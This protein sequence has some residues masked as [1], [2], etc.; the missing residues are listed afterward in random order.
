MV[1][2]NPRRPCCGRSCVSDDALHP[3]YRRNMQSTAQKASA[4]DLGR[5][6][7]R[8]VTRFPRH[9]TSEEFTSNPR[10]VGQYIGL[11]SRIKSLFPRGGNSPAPVG[12][13]KFLINID[14]CCTHP[15]CTS[16][17][18]F[19]P[20]VLGLSPMSVMYSSC[21]GGCGGRE[22]GLAYGAGGGRCISLPA[23]RVASTTQ[24]THCMH[25]AK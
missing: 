2:K 1:D 15:S 10:F 5:A 14:F 13:S 24:H 19:S 22:E 20:L 8:R 12:L 3:R 25:L 23:H 6:P 18:P 16:F 21:L 11:R 17:R 9:Y 4:K 7:I